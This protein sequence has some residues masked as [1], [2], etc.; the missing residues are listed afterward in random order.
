MK[1]RKRASWRRPG[2]PRHVDRLTLKANEGHRMRAF[3]HHII[4]VGREF[5]RFLHVER[6]ILHRRAT[7]E[8][9]SC[10]NVSYS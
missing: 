4:S 3:I 6:A 8:T 5:D 2:R 7:G 10:P 1:L 9:L